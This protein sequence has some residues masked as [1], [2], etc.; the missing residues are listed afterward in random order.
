MNNSDNL[1]LIEEYKARIN[2]VF[3]YVENN[4]N[5]NLSLEELASIANFSKFHFHR[6]FYGLTRETPFQFILRLRLEKAASYLI[7]NPKKSITEIALECG[8]TDSAVFARSFKAKFSCSATHW[9]RQKQNSNQSKEEGIYNQ[10]ISNAGRDKKTSSLYFSSVFNNLQWSI[11]MELLKKVEVKEVEKFTVAYVRY[12][13]P[14]AGDGKLFERLFNKLFTWAGP[15]Q[16]LR[17]KDMKT[18]VVYHD[19]IEITDEDKLRTSVCISVPD[20][21]VVDGEIGKM[22]IPSGKYVFARFEVGVDEFGKAWDWVYSS[23]F[24]SSGYQPD[25]GPCFEYYP[26]EHKGGKFVVEICVPVK[27]L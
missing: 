2:R 20:N 9:R 21:T 23:W 22:E 4:L 25:D 14:Y 6:I 5:R 8:F 26:E 3:D 16:L 18:I 12:I 19:N 17:Q 11:N 7:N 13:G 10:T 24:P 27:P 1:F 15:R